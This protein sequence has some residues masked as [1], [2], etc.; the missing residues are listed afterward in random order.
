VASL[1][2]DFNEMTDALAAK[3]REY[4]DTANL[5]GDIIARLDKH[6][7]WAFVNDAVCRFYGKPREELLGTDSR[8]FAH[9][10]DLKST[11]QRIRKTS[12]GKK[13]HKG[14]VNRQVT[15]M[16]IK[17]VEWNGCPL[18]D[19]K[20]QYA[21][22]QIT[23]RDITERKQMEEELRESE[24]KFRT[25]LE[26]LPQKIFSKD[27]NSVY[28]SCNEN[29]AQ[30]L[31][32]KPN[33]IAGKTDYDFFPKELAEKYRADDKR[34]MQSGKTED[35]EEAY[36][37][38]GKEVFVHTIKTPVRD[39]DDN[40]VGILGVFW[41]ITERKRM[42]DAL[43]E[44]EERFRLLFENA[45]DAIF[46]ADPRT[47]LITGCNRAAETLLERGRA[48]IIGQPQAALHPPQ[49]A[50]HYAEM[51]KRHIEEEGFAEDEAEVITKS[52]RTRSV[53]ITA[54]LASVRGEPIIQGVFR[55]ITERKQA[56]EALR[57]SEERY[58]DLFESATDLVQS[59][60]P[61]GSLVYVNRA[62]REALGYEE[63]EIAGLSLFDIIHPDSAAHC[64][65][66]FERVMAGEKLD[67]VEAIFVAKDGR[68]ISVEGNVNW[69][70][71]DGKP[72]ATRG[73]FRD[74]TERKR[75]EEELRESEERFRSLS[76]SAPIGVFLLD[77]RGDCVYANPRLQS[78]SGL[79][80]E[81]SLG[82][83]WSKVIHPDD[84]AA[85]LEAAEK[86]AHDGRDFSHELR[87]VTPEGELR[88][89]HVHT[90]P[91][92]SAQGKQTGRV[93]TIEDI[94]DS[95]Q[96]QEE[97][98]RL[99]AELE[100]RAITDGLTGLYNHAHFFQRLAEEIDRSKRYGRGF[101]ILMMDVDNFKQLNDTRGHQVGDVAL[102]LVADCVRT[103]VRRSDIAF[104]YGGDEFAAILLHADSSRAQAIAKRINRCV[105]RRLEQANDTAAA[106]LGL[107]AGIA[108]FP[109][110]A[111][112][113]DDLVKIADTALYDAK[114]VTHARSAIEQAQAAGSLATT[115][116]TVHSKG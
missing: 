95:K 8:A 4:I 67:H 51:F 49:K 81:E 59:A 27:K 101:A 19:E 20:D 5:T 62:W 10:D 66:M 29:Y 61:D 36:V 3:T 35:M 104:R 22:I 103:G 26:N 116:A 115:K 110:D 45:K 60:A 6:G 76:A 41:D 106:W 37:Q 54:S 39:G 1:A 91:M 93:G 25:L 68:S 96:A 73:I 75:M 16:G 28:M 88:W 92:F 56:E 86:A 14:F 17:V 108:S 102:C 77:L 42:E 31:N 112:T 111:T 83:G 107:S 79:T 74:I 47:G 32:I 46:H 72:V 89:I 78:I 70:F 30:D 87:I 34:I 9:P 113:A 2:R 11:A 23:G 40:V 65:K 43:R 114:R 38:D 94:T 24:N 99:H 84:R 52:G 85:A 58:R 57:E 7:N 63:S 97:R 44:S 64:M 69:R 100:V 105:T 12:A 15:P 48:Q 50:Q 21:G 71:E 90:S 18:F 33:E 55:D 98:E 13:L 82:Y 80:L 109:D 53:L